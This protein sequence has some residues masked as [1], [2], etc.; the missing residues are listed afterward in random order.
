MVSPNNENYLKSQIVAPAYGALPSKASKNSRRLRRE[1]LNND[2]DSGMVDSLLIRVK[3][4]I[5]ESRCFSK[6]KAGG[7]HKTQQ[8]AAKDMQKFCH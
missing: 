3:K 5:K 2:M 7:H 6:G 8:G 1:L 4:H